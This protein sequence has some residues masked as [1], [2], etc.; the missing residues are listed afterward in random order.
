MKV[1]SMTCC[2]SKMGKKIQR[3]NISASCIRKRKGIKRKES[4]LMEEIKF[5]YILG[6]KLTRKNKTGYSRLEKPEP[7]KLYFSQ[8][9]TG[10]ITFFIMCISCP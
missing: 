9:Q 1:A 7:I 3:T 4:S 8:T 10:L 6:R 5:Y 2:L